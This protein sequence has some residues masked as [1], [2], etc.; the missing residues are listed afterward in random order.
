MQGPLGWQS[1]SGLSTDPL[2]NGDIEFLIN[3]DKHT[4]VSAISWEATIQ[5]HIEEELYDSSL[6]VLVQH[7]AFS[8]KK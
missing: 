6:Q 4:E 8:H 1:F 7:V 2:L 5:K 3:A